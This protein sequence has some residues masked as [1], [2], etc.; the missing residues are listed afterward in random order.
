MG[1]FYY[2]AC[3]I[4]DLIL[5]T[6]GYK[7]DVFHR[8]LFWDIEISE[9]HGGVAVIRMTNAHGR[10]AGKTSPSDP[11]KVDDIMETKEATETVSENR[12]YLLS[13]DGEED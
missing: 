10:W 6:F 12:K 1:D 7:I 4:L 8:V 13:D 3:F 5:D 9:S 2:A 11:L